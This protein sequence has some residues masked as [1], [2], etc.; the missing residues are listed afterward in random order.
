[1]P[2]HKNPPKVRTKIAAMGN[3]ALRASGKIFKFTPETARAAAAKGRENKRM[4]KMREEARYQEE[5]DR[6]RRM[7]H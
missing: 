1:M 3:A 6:L 2:L 4:K 5:L 7:G